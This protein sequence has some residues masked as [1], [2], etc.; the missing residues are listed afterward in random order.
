M[1]QWVKTDQGGPWADLTGE[2]SAKATLDVLSK[3]REEIN[4]KLMNIHV[5]GWENTG[6]LH[7]YDGAE[8][9]W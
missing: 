3:N 7:S 5:A 6:K 4:G 9:A 1:Q 8:I 2:E